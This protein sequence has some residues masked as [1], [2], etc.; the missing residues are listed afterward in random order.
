ML[1]AASH[2]YENGVIG[3]NLNTTKILTV[4][5]K[6]ISNNNISRKEEYKQGKD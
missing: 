3:I 4:T 5:A 2:K 6:A 1:N